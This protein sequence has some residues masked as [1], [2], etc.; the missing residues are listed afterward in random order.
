MEAV[1]RHTGQEQAHVDRKIFFHAHNGIPDGNET[2]YFA[3]KQ[4]LY[5]MEYKERDFV[6]AQ[7]GKM[8]KEGINR[9]SSPEWASPMVLA[10]MGDVFVSI[11]EG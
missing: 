9:P 4:K 11:I 5:R 10:P 6:K 1:P 3:C 8:M 2:R 7:V